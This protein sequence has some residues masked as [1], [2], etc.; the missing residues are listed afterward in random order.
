M[1]PT[2]QAQVL[3]LSKQNRCRGEP[4]RGWLGCGGDIMQQPIVTRVLLLSGVHGLTGQR[5]LSKQA[6]HPS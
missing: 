6:I 1:L 4:V 3:I 5:P 2:R